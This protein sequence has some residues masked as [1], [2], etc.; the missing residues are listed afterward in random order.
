MYRVWNR[1]VPCASLCES[2]QVSIGGRVENTGL[3]C[4]CSKS[5]REA[6]V[7]VSL[8]PGLSS[9]RDLNVYILLLIQRVRS[10]PGGR[11]CEEGGSTQNLK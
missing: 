11:A 9:T 8:G 7:C 3:K 1:E 4:M 10:P 6:C 5:R 2:A